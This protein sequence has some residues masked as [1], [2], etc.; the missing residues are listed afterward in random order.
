MQFISG[1]RRSI[2]EKIKARRNN[3]KTREKG[4]NDTYTSPC[5]Q[6]T[7]VLQLL[8]F[9]FARH[10]DPERLASTGPLDI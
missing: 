2:S 10:S 4:L 9:Y 5:S 7:W 8:L 1:T 6:H 3:L